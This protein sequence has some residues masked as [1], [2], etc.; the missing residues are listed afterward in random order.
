[1]GR[2]GLAAC[3]IPTAVYLVMKT[4]QFFLDKKRKISNHCFA[5]NVLIVF[6][7]YDV[8]HYEFSWPVIVLPFVF[9]IGIEILH[10][11]GLS[12]DPYENKIINCYSWFD[13]IIRS[14]KMG[15]TLDM[16]E[17]KYDG[18]FLKSYESAQKD[19]RNWILDQGRVEKGVRVLDIGSGNG[20]LLEMVK[21]RGGTAKGITLSPEQQLFCR[22]K[23]M[24]VD[25]MNVWNLDENYFGRYDVLILNGS[26]EHFVNAS[27]SFH[28]RK[29]KKYR[30]LFGLLAKLFDPDSAIKRIVITCIHMDR[31]LRDY[32]LT[33]L[34]QGYLYGQSYGG[35][36]Q[37]GRNGL[38]KY[39]DDFEVLFQEDHTLD[40]YISSKEY[41]RRVN[42]GNRERAIIIKCL[43]RYPLFLINDPYFVHKLLHQLL[44]SWTWQFT[45]PH[46]PNCHQWIVLRKKTAG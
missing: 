8:M 12:L 18:C 43:K 30:R 6:A 7:V 26:L 31:P 28:N 21:E 16:T 17:G 34:I 45:P 9:E 35:G 3:L 19:Q 40:Y 25:L 24:D 23:G 22:S 11:C 13:T 5:R 4:G 38:V 33:D 14:K 10:R 20:N 44:G 1:M 46:P 32:R 37:V 42:G 29:E 27:D 39:A 41:W 15:N 36:L 2:F